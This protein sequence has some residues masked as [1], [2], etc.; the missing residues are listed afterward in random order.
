MRSEKSTV[1]YYESNRRNIVH[2]LH[3]HGLHGYGVEI[4]VKKGDF[5]KHLLQYWNCSK[6]FM[7]DPWCSQPMSVYDE[8]H[9]YNADYED[10]LKNVSPFPGKYEIVREFSHNAYQRF[11]DDYFDFVYLDGNHSYEAV[12]TDL[13]Q[14]YPKLKRHGLMAGDDYTI[15]PV[16]T[17]FGYTFGVKQAVDEFAVEHKKNVSIDLNGDWMYDINGVLVPSRNWYFIK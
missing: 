4:G 1:Q 9:D 11:A 3:K 16:E 13:E 10:C 8:M 17:V 5:S 6:L 14:W 7:V 12:K 15:N 2:V